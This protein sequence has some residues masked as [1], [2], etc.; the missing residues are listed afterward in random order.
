MKRLSLPLG[1]VLGLVLAAPVSAA[2][3]AFT[4]EWIGND[5]AP[6]DGDGSVVHVSISGGT[7]AQITFT[8]EFGTICVHNGS[9]VT[10]FTSTLVGV[11]NGDTLDARF[12]SARCGP[13]PLLFLRG[14]PQ[15][16]TLDD[17][18]NTDPSDDTI[19]DGFATWHRA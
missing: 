18:G 6:P 19:W 4:G 5:P 12:T 11:V 3:T 13:V 7:R 10:E 16:W 9:P 14:V 15:T 1:I 2:T 8:D 17:Q